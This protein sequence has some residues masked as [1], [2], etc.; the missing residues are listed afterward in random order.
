MKVTLKLFASLGDRLPPEARSSHAM[1]VETGPA[2]TVGDVI[3]KEGIPEELCAIVLVDGNWVP[4][5]ERADRVL[6]EGQVV[7]IW[8]P[9]GGG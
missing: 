2:G 9:V 7:A 6:R 8:P 3:R 1:E 5:S 4:R